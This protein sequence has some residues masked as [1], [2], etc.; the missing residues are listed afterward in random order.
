MKRVATAAMAGLVVLAGLVGASPAQAD[1]YSV[2]LTINSVTKFEGESYTLT[3]KASP[4]VDCDWTLKAPGKT[5][6]EE[7][8][9]AT[10]SHSFK[11]P[12]VS[13]DTVFTSKV[14]CKYSGTDPA[15]PIPEALGFKGGALGFATAVAPPAHTVSAT[16]TVTVLQK[17]GN[18][19]N[20][21]GHHHKKHGNKDD[22]DDNGNLPNTGG[23]RLAWL[24]IGLLLVAAGTTVVVSSRKRE[25][26]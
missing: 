11:A 16:G 2:D 7:D 18:H 9:G 6:T 21:N 14:T 12:D 25:T 13:H 20:G 5:V 19:H 15:F 23:E 1:G 26:V 3:A 4:A 22:D 17:G 8:G 24:V 10:I